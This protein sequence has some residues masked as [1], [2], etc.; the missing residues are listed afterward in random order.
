VF[1]QFAGQVKAA[2]A[3]TDFIQTA[4]NY[5]SAKTDHQIRNYYDGFIFPVPC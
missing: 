4:P 1:V 3:A 2:V 5:Y